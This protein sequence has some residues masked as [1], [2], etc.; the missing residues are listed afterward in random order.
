MGL[1]NFV[2]KFD[3]IQEKGIKEGL[4][5]NDYKEL[6]SILKQLKKNGINNDKSKEL[7]KDINYVISYMRANGVINK[8]S[9][10]NKEYIKANSLLLPLLVEDTQGEIRMTGNNTFT[11][12][13]VFHEDDHNDL[14]LKDFDNRFTCCTCREY[15]DVIDYVMKFHHFNRVPEALE[16]LCKVYKFELPSNLKSVNNPDIQYLAN[17]YRDVFEDDICLDLLN[18]AEERLYSR[19]IYE[20]GDQRVEDIYNQRRDTILRVRNGEFDPNFIYDKP[21]KFVKLKKKK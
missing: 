16:F 14:L 7:E 9:S 1:E 10:R 11:F 12:N 6:S 8:F 19:G 15:G 3:S 13:C 20:M 4:T 17:G 21:K 18:S 5:Y 2:K